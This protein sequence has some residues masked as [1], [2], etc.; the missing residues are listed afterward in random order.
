M[1][2]HALLIIGALAIIE[3]LSL[4]SLTVIG[5]GGLLLLLALVVAAVEFI[6]PLN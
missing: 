1:M 5:M 6:A 4:P 3:G 2:T